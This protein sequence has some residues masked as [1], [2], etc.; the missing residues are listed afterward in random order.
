M[1]FLYSHILI[2]CYF[3][4]KIEGRRRS[5]YRV[6][7]LLTKIATVRIDIMNIIHLHTDKK[8]N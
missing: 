7:L 8:S 3:D 1:Y 4:L 2:L 5:L 6:R